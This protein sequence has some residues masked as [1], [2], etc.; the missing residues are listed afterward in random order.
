MSY[1][2]IHAEVI[3]NGMRGDSCILIGAWI[4]KIHKSDG[5]PVYLVVTHPD[6]AEISFR[7]KQNR[8]LLCYPSDWPGPGKHRPGCYVYAKHERL[9][10][11]API[12]LHD[13][14]E[15]E[16]DGE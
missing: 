8:R 15:E 16:T 6:G 11:N 10:F 4:P 5:N 9:P 7:S 14:S 12:P 2:G 1:A 13:L 3:N